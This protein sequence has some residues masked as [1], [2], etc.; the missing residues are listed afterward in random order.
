MAVISMRTFTKPFTQQEPISEEAIARAVAV[1]R[2]GRLHR[3][4]TIE[5]E[6]SETALLEKEFADYLGTPYAL[7]PACER[8]RSRPLAQE[9][10]ACLWLRFA[11]QRRGVRR[12]YGRRRDRTSSFPDLRKGDA[13]SHRAG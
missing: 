4:N 9:A 2:S 1:M 7:L 13:A 5:G 10:A 3:Y 11:H 6:E 12:S 8:L